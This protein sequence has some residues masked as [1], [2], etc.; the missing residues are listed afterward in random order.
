MPD[1]LTRQYA[2]SSQQLH[3]QDGDRS[4]RGHNRPWWNFNVIPLAL[5]LF[6]LV[7]VRHLWNAGN[8]VIFG[9]VAVIFTLWLLVGCLGQSIHRGADRHG[10]KSMVRLTT[11]YTMLAVGLIAFFLLAVLVVG[12]LSGVGSL[13]ALSV[14]FWEQLPTLTTFI[15]LAIG[16]SVVAGKQSQ[17]P[18][19]SRYALKG[20]GGLMFTT[21]L[22]ALLS[23]LGFSPQLRGL[24]ITEI[25]ILSW[26]KAILLSI[27]S[28]TS[29]VFIILALL[30]DRNIESR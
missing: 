13:R 30:S 15:V 6:P 5:A 23:I 7:Y 14:L 19:V 20:I 12:A 16:F 28:A 25:L 11:A 26:L 22:A 18:N 21:F 8:S 2:L 10:M 9:S 3:S 4:I 27:A 17:Q 1:E 24:S 29:W